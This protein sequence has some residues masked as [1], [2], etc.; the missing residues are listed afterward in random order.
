M[1]ATLWATST[2]SNSTNYLKIQKKES[3][4]NDGLVIYKNASGPFSEKIKKDIFANCLEHDLEVENVLDVTFNLED[5]S[6]H[7]YLKDNNKRTIKEFMSTQNSTIPRP[8]SSS[9]QNQQ[10]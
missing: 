3:Q 1:Y 10:N 4:S 5:S 6:Y 8:W 2:N 7:P 9:F